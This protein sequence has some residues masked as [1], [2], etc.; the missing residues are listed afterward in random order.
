MDHGVRLNHID[1]FRMGRISVDA[2]KGLSELQRET[3]I[4]AGEPA[5]QQ[6]RRSVVLGREVTPNVRLDRLRLSK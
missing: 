2:A 1:N 5:N 3:A 4:Y 6:L